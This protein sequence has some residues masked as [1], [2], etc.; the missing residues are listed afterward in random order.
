MLDLDNFKAY[1]DSCGHLAGD[2]ILNSTA[3]AMKNVLHRGCDIFRRYGGEEFIAILPGT[4]AAGAALIAERMRLAVLHLG[5]FHPASQAGVVTVS[6]GVAAGV[7]NHEAGIAE[8]IH[9]ADQALYQA[10][11]AGKNRIE[12]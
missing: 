4:D 11:Q 9:A 8:L 10:K 3:Q 2:E 1:N 12:T 5:V 6:G 7:P